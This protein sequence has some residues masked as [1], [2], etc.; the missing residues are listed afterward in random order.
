MGTKTRAH[1]GAT[2]RAHFGPAMCTKS[3]ESHRKCKMRAHFGAAR[4]PHSES[5]FCPKRSHFESHFGRPFRPPYR[6]P[7]RHHV[8]P[9]EAFASWQWLNHLVS[10]VP[11]GK[12]A[13][14][15]NMGE[16][17]VCLYQGTGKGTVMAGKKRKRDGSVQRGN[18]A[19]R[20][21]YLTPMRQCTTMHE[22]FGFVC[23]VRSSL[24]CTFRSNTSK[25][26]NTT[27]R[28]SN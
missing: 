25:F 27:H 10:K 5:V 13:L 21:K 23:R 1:F 24:D 7:F 12:K 11:A 19:T 20:R 4:R 16:T 2:M 3:K 17:A 15:I 28:Q 26:C 22:L 18:R 9:G 6:P 14:I 8:F